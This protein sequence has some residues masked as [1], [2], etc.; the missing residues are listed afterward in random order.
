M[1]TGKNNNNNKIIHSFIRFL[2]I[3]FLQLHFSSN[4]NTA[5]ISFYFR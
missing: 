4:N 5:T 3:D 1:K 2:K